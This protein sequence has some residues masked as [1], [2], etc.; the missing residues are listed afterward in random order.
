MGIAHCGGIA[1]TGL[2]SP[3][4]GVVCGR[5][6]PEGPKERTGFPAL[7][8]LGGES[9]LSVSDCARA[10]SPLRGVEDWHRTLRRYRVIRLPSPLEGRGWGWG[11]A[12]RAEERT[13]FPALF[14]RGGESPH[15]VSGCPRATQGEP[16]VSP[17]LRTPHHYVG[18]R[19]GPR[20]ALSS[21]A[22]RSG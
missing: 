19:K 15:S 10:T 3:L 9:P 20:A 12:R 7:F 6:R 11:L 21:P 2:S 1:R 17:V 4:R 8:R 5:V 22:S 13:W 18:A 16:P 14:R